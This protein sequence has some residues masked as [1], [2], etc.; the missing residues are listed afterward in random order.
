MGVFMLCEYNPMLRS[1]NDMSSDGCFLTE[2]MTETRR[3]M[4]HHD[5]CIAMWL[6]GLTC[7]TLLLVGNQANPTVREAG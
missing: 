4:H 3:E 2:I 6:A 5:W 1:V 7:H